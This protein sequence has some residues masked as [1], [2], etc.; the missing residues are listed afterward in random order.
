MALHP[1]TGQTGPNYPDFN[2]R[3]SREALWIDGR[4]NPPWVASAG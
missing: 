4:Y 1:G 2:H 3:V